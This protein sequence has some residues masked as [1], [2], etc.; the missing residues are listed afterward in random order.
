[1][2][3][4]WQ[5][6]I[7]QYLGIHCTA[8]G[9]RALSQAAYLVTLRQ[10]SEWVRIRLADA[11]PGT[12]HARDVLE[13]VQHL[14]TDRGNGDAAVNRQVT[15]LRSFYRAL[16]AMEL[17]EPRQN[18]LAHFPRIKGVSRKLPSTLTREEMARLLEAPPA[19]TEIGVRDRAML[20]LLYSTGIRA[21]ECAGLRVADVDLQ[22]ERVTVKGKGGHQ[23]AVPLNAEVIKWLRAYVSV[24]GLALPAAP[25]FRSRFG[26]PLSRGTLYERVR[27]WARKARI[28][29]RV[30]PHVLRHTFATHLVQERVQ[31]VTIR[32]LLGHRLITSTQIYL[33]VTAQDL[34]IAADKHPISRLLST[35]EHL[36]PRGP[37]PFQAPRAGPRRA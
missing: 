31:L 6:A 18:P 30:S 37:L 2:N 22:G 1:M 5:V 34:R 11:P 33:H 35:V 32:D 17:I 9:L 4:T 25:F 29:K 15:V 24:R 3:L 10:F 14:R 13:Y 20:A 23:R 26:E 19:D 28:A 21:S 12:V 7:E 27:F 16:V 8:R 36:L